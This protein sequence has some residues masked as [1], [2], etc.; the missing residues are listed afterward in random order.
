VGFSAS[1][2][3]PEEGGDVAVVDPLV[4]EPRLLPINPN[5]SPSQARKIQFY[6]KSLCRFHVYVTQ[7]CCPKGGG[8]GVRGFYPE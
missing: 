8:G 5:F 1:L 4:G 2:G 7:I 3:L 6:K